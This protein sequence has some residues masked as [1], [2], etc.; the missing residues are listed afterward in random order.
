MRQDSHAIFAATS[1]AQQATDYL[2]S[3]QPAAERRCAAYGFGSGPR[4]N[5]RS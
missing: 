2:F 4:R 5:A 1:K 3:L